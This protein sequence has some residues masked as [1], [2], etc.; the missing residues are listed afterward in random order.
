MK[1]VCDGH[2]LGREEAAGLMA[3]AQQSQLGALMRSLGYTLQP[4]RAPR[5]LTNGQVIIRLTW[6]KRE[7]NAVMTVRTTIRLHAPK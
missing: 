7:A 6:S 3:D 5:G 2:R 1:I 4:L